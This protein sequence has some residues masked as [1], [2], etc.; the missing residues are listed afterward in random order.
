MSNSNPH[1]FISI[2]NPVKGQRL[3]PRL[4]RHLPD[5]Q[6]LTLLTLLIATYSQL[7]VVAHAPPPPVSDTSLL[8][9]AD[10][11]NRARREVETDNFLSCVI[12][13]VDTLI[14]RCNLGLVAGL[15]GICGQ[16]MEVWEVAATR[17]NLTL[18]QRS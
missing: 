15:L 13:G 8:D 1:P 7:D 14:N 18:C 2:L 4:L 5:Q 9:K 16:R 11:L 6:A 10:R 17:V 12:P 3:F